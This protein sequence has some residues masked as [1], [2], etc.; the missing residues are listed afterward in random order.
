MS[1]ALAAHVCVLRVG[2]ILLA[3]AYHV[4]MVKEL[5]SSNQYNNVCR[6]SDGRGAFSISV[7]E[8]PVPFTVRCVHATDTC[9]VE[10]E[11]GAC[12]GVPLSKLDEDADGRLSL[13]ETATGTT[14]TLSEIVESKGWARDCTMSASP[15]T[16][17]CFKHTG[18]D[19]FIQL[20]G[21]G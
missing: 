7:G 17:A 6:A 1:L 11:D 5:G 12:Q 15:E 8:P 21:R 10:S 13:A 2:R 18:E 20:I 19:H 16:A 3:E 14:I 4:E 9:N